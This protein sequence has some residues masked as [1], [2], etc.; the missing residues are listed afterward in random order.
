MIASNRNQPFGSRVATLHTKAFSCI[1]TTAK[2]GLFKKQSTA[3]YEMPRGQLSPRTPI[4]HLIYNES[5]SSAARIEA[6]ELVARELDVKGDK[7]NSLSEAIRAV[8]HTLDVR[9][10]LSEGRIVD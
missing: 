2:Q 9:G 5:L 10:I 8:A 3:I 4:A 6:H 1:V 7:G